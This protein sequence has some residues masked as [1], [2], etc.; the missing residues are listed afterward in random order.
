MH[1]ISDRASIVA[2]RES[3]QGGPSNILH[4]IRHKIKHL[5]NHGDIIDTAAIN[6]SDCVDVSVEQILIDRR[7]KTIRRVYA[8]QHVN[9][10]KVGWIVDSDVD[11]CMICLRKFSF[12]RF[13]HHCRACG[14]LVCG[15]CSP[16]KTH[17]PLLEED[18]GSRVCI[19]CFGLK[20]EVVAIKLA[21]KST[22]VHVPGGP[23]NIFSPSVQPRGFVKRRS[24]T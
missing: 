14:I 4:H 5:E 22:P 24:S 6:M 3:T 16:F 11:C 21:G 13:R 20:C 18:G 23:E 8:L 15:S 7:V 17:I 10:Y 2:I 9:S 19:N 12:F 1:R